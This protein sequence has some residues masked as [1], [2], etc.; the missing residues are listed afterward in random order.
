MQLLASNDSVQCDLYFDL[1]VTLYNNPHSHLLNCK[2]K[3]LWQR[4]SS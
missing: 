2:I 1:H 3:L 4:S